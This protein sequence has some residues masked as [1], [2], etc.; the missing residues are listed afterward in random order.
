MNVCS[1]CS[2]LRPSYNQLRS[3]VVFDG[4]IRNAIHNLKY[5]KD[6]SLAEI[7]SRPLIRLVSELPW[8]IDIVIPVPLSENRLK[9]RGYNQAALLALPIS[10]AMGYRYKPKAL[11]RVRDTES[12]VGLSLTQRRTNVSGAF[13]AEEK[14]VYRKNILLV[15]DVATSGATLNACADALF[16]AQANDVNAITLARAMYN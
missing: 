13:I 7:F 3:W 14:I 10:L 5:Q 12:Q 9:E 8:K 11:R 16:F 15:D 4:E 1:R 2:S 6:L